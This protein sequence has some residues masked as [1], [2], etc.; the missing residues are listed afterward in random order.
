MAI[1]LGVSR[2]LN[3]RLSEALPVGSGFFKNI[4]H[5][6][7]KG[8]LSPA[9]TVLLLTYL[10]RHGALVSSVEIT[11]YLD[12]D[13]VPDPGWLEAIDQSSENPAAMGERPHSALKVD[14]ESARLF[15]HDPGEAYNR[16]EQFGVDR[17]HPRW[18]EIRG[19]GDWAWVQHV[20][21][22][23]RSRCGPSSMSEP[24]PQRI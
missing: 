23:Q 21:A 16:P 22:P 3:T 17:S 8:L 10:I 20:S 14:T 15:S 13:S 2:R 9:G 4:N 24:G 5:C 11:A 6:P 19:L 1:K 7:F 12:D 18:F